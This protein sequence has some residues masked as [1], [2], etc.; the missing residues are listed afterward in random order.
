VK[1]LLLAAVAA[2]LFPLLVMLLFRAVPIRRRAAAMLRLF[3]ATVP[4]YV[5]AYAATPADLRFL[6]P[7]LV[8]PRFV[9]ACAF[10]LFVYGALFFGGWLQVYNLADRGCAL[11]IL[12][13]IGESPDRAMSAPEIEIR[14]ERGRGLH[15]MADKRIEDILAIGLATLRAGRLHATPKGARVARLFGPLRAFLHLDDTQ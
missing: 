5:G 3:L 9:P 11:H 6:S 7:W 13:A 8:E 14:Y 15:W 4:L 1:G 2:L 10:G 12:L